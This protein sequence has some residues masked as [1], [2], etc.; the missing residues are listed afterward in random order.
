MTISAENLEILLT[1]SIPHEYTLLLPVM[2]VPNEDEMLSE[3]KPLLKRP[4]VGEDCPV[5]VENTS[6][7]SG[8]SWM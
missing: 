8:L 1:S 6:L 3:K 7:C 4:V 2:P 5:E